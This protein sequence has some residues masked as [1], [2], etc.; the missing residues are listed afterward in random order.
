MGK[1]QEKTAQTQQE[2]PQQEASQQ[3]VSKQETPEQEVSKQKEK[4]DVAVT[5]TTAMA[6]AQKIAKSIFKGNPAMKEVHVTSDGTAF[7]T[8]NDAK[9]HARALSNK[10]VITLK[11]KDVQ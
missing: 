10:G 11:R 6:A 5:K 4:T 8:L 3:E 9:N 1:K 2:T 7:Y